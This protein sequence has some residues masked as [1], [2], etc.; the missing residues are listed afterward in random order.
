MSWTTDPAQ[1]RWFAEVYW[2]R[3]SEGAGEIAVI[4]REVILTKS[5]LSSALAKGAVPSRDHPVSGAAN[6]TRTDSRPAQRQREHVDAVPVTV[7]CAREAADLC[8]IVGNCTQ[9]TM[10]SRSGATYWLW[11]VA[12]Q[13]LRRATFSFTRTRNR[14]PQV[15]E[16]SQI[17][18]V[19]GYS[20]CAFAKN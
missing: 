20:Y 4:G 19:R 5:S 1:A 8:C 16:S 10:F 9:L 11:A 18:M 14:Q 17:E 3:R 7:R 12:T 6:E 2:P 13:D 15:L